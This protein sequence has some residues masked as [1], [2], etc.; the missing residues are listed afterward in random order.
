M[1]REVLSL[2]CGK[3]IY[4][5][6]VAS[7]ARSFRWHNRDNAISFVIATDD[8]QKIP[9]DVAEWCE[10]H[11]IE[12]TDA[13]G[14]ELKLSLDLYAKADR[15]LFIDADCLVTRDLTEV[16]DSF[17]GKTFTCLGRNLSEGEWFGNIAE[18]CQAIGAEQI[19]VFVGAVYYFERGSSSKEVFDEARA[20]A[21]HYDEL[22]IV[23]LRGRKN[24]EPL[25]SIG[26]A[27]YGFQA[28]KD[29]GDFKCDVMGFAGLVKINIPAGTVEFNE[30]RRD[31]LHVPYCDEKAHP[32]IAHFNDAFTSMWEYRKET[33][34][35]R[36]IM[37][38]GKSASAAAFTSTLGTEL[39]GRTTRFLKETLRPVYHAIFGARKI[40]QN[41]R[42]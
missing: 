12:N 24:E 17:E 2:A 9:P 21:E 14:F 11:V 5:E 7:L 38:E 19:P 31:F 10:V 40:K 27:R 16:F 15:T 28:S 37:A 30:P 42:L 1:T 36:M 6:M 22:G 20:Q 8:P 33:K 18:R 35:L 3:Q 13:V 23:R 26:M 25:I 34:R 29:T 39:P 32:A 41:E 4:F